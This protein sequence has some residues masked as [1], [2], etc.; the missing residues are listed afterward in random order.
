MTAG[1]GDVSATTAES[2]AP[3]KKERSFLGL[4]LP[5]VSKQILAFAAGMLTVLV[6]NWFNAKSAHLKVTVPDPFVYKGEKTNFTI[7]NV[8]VTNDG[9]QEAENVECWLMHPGAK[10]Q[11]VK[12]GPDQLNPV[13]TKQESKV[14]IVAKSLNPREDFTISAWLNT[15]ENATEQPKV[16]VRGKGLVGEREAKRATPSSE[17]LIISIMAALGAGMMM[18][19][20]RDL[21]GILKLREERRKLEEEWRRLRNS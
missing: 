8:T 12:A 5:D 10:V 3:A 14:Q 2:A 20:I 15:A 4:T 21:R 17:V 1:D 7:V 9:N 13:V 18:Q 11:E 16:E 19:L 6:T